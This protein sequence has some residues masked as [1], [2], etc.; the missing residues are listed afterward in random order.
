MELSPGPHD[1][2]RAW[3]DDSDPEPEPD[4]DAQA[5]AYVARVLGPPKV[6]QALRRPPLLSAPVASTGALEPRAAS[7]GP[8]VGVP[9][10]LSL[11]P[12]LLLEICAYLDARLVLHVLPRVCHTL[13]DLVRDRV[14]WRL[15]AQRRVRA[16]YPVVEEE[17]FDWPTACIELEQH[18]SRWAEDGRWAEYF[19]LADGHFASIDSVLLLQGWVWSLAALDHRV[20]SGSWDSTVK[21][22]D[23]AADGQQFGEIKGKAAVLCLSYQPDIL[24]TGTYDKKVTVYDPRVGPA[25]LK[26]RRLHSS[27]VLALLADDRHIISG[28][29]DHTLVVFDRRANS[30]LQ[31]LQ[32]D[33][34]LLCMSYQEPQLWAGDNQGLLHVFANHNGCFQLVR[35]FDVGHRSQITGIKHSLGALYTTSTD[36]TIRV[37]VPTDPPRTICTRSHNN[38]LNGICAE[39]N[40]VVA[41]SGGLSL[42]VW[43]LQA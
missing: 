8:P 29:E 24:V 22:W 18:L 3:D 12:E 11:P 1:D 6:G 35:S 31:R 20:C 27:A 42:E 2:P 9:G 5:E 33:S 26:S 13:R 41:A 10:L 15:R 39:G 36:K 14:T 37:H 21:L 38:V 7:K 19:C 40:L 34:Y 4:P 25:L 32:L 43:R 23:M 16:P 17:D 30:V 28:S